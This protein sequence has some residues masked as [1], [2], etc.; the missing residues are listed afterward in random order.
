MHQKRG[1]NDPR[2]NYHSGANIS[3]K[4]KLKGNNQMIKINRI[5]A[6]FQT[7]PNYTNYSSSGTEGINTPIRDST[8]TFQNQRAIWTPS[9]TSRLPK[10]KGSPKIS[11]K[12][13]TQQITANS[14]KKNPNIKDRGVKKSTKKPRRKECQQL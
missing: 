10:E 11:R 6:N 4:K 5:Q 3:Q 14:N 2:S 7:T 12:E 13:K 9:N 8:L 1:Q